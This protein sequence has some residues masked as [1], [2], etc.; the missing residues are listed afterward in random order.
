MK[1]ELGN[2]PQMA[3]I[4]LQVECELPLW[5]NALV[6]GAPPHGRDSARLYGSPV[7]ELFCACSIFCSRRPLMLRPRIPVWK[8]SGR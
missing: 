4:A 7:I 6:A 1:F 2:D 5:R 3:Q 8:A